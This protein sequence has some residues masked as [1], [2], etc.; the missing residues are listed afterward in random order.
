MKHGYRGHLNVGDT[1]FKNGK[2]YGQILIT[3]PIYS[4]HLDIA[5]TISRPQYNFFY[6]K[7]P[8]ISR[9][10]ISLS[11]RNCSFIKKIKINKNTKKVTL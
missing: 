10:K 8:V 4:G 7:V 1:F 3:K 2:N 9:Q 5:D 6:R 11:Y